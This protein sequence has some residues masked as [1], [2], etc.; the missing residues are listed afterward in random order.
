MKSCIIFLMLLNATHALALSSSEPT[1]KDLLTLSD[2]A[3]DMT[4]NG[5]TVT[6]QKTS[7]TGTGISS[8]QLIYFTSS[9]C[10]LG[11]SAVFATL[12][13]APFTIP[14]STFFGLNPGAAYKVGH[15][16]LSLDMTT[17]QS[18]KLAFVDLPGLANVLFTGSC[19]I[20]GS[21]GL[22][23]CVAVSCS[24]GTQQCTSS[25]GTQSVTLN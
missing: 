11:A 12:N 17:M 20:T 22:G 23:C 6:F 9:D 3:S 13:N 21:L 15:T 18:I 8:A 4:L 2:N 24:N 25:I 16:V 7:G 1:L 5:Q 19:A 14:G 10:T